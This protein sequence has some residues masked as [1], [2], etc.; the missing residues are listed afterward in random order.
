[1]PWTRL[2][3]EG[4]LK[5]YLL[6]EEQ[7]GRL[8]TYRQAL[9]EAQTQAMEIDPKVFLMG[10][11]VDDPGGVFG[12]TLDLHKRF[13]RERVI[14]LPLAENGFTGVAIGAAITGM[15]PVVIHMRNDFLLLAMDQ[16][17]NHAAKWRYMFGSRQ[18]IPLTIRA[19]I[20]RGWGSGAQHSQ[21]LQALFLHPAGLKVVMPAHP[22]DVKGLLL[23][24][25]AD[26]DPV[27]FIEHRWLYDLKGPV[28]QEAYT[29][30]LGKGVIRRP[31]RDATVVAISLMVIEAMRAAEEL[32]KDRIEIEIIDPR[33]LKPLDLD[34]ILESLSRT[35]RLVVADTGPSM[36]GASAEIAALVAEHG[37]GLLKSPIKRVALPDTPTPASPVLEEAYYPGWRQIV[38]AVESLLKERGD[39]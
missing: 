8:L 3:A 20:G 31:G 28:P 1:M 25:I 37:F 24:S 34:I 15:R 5:T 17:I 18:H 36:A 6:E 7:R 10:E 19:I 39:V 9:L 26:P 14:D 11:G 35:G 30:P 4:Y 21:S 16:I 27:I 2:Q 33:S 13:G 32:K 23:S 29:I 12:S 22:F 38:G